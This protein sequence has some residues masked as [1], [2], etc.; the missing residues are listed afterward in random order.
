MLLA[1]PRESALRLLGEDLK[2]MYQ[3]I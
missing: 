3:K 1:I 2:I